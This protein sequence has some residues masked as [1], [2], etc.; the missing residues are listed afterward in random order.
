M[1]A[2]SIITKVNKSLNVTIGTTPFRKTRNG[3]IAALSAALV[4]ILGCQGSS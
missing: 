2:Q 1:I 4:S 3:C